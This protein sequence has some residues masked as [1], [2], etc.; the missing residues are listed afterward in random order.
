[1]KGILAFALVLAGA[2]V[3]PIAAQAGGAFGAAPNVASV[4]SGGPTVLAV[5]HNGEP[6]VLGVPR[7]PGEPS[8]LGIPQRPFP[9]QVQPRHH[10][11]HQ[12]QPVWVQPQWAWDGWQWVWVPGYWVW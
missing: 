5:P 10:W 8:V 2:L 11:V 6:S 9:S 3:A 12:R 4:P 7:R 1:M